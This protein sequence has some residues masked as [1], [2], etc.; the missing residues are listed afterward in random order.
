[1]PRKGGNKKADAPEV[2][3]LPVAAGDVG[4]GACVCRVARARARCSH[5][6]VFRW[7]ATLSPCLASSDEAAAGAPAFRCAVPMFV[8]TRAP[9]T[10]PSTQ[11]RFGDLQM[12]GS[13]GVDLST[14]PAIVIK[15][16][17]AVEGIQVRS[18]RHQHGKSCVCAALTPS[19]R[20]HS[21][22]EFDKLHSQHL[23]ELVELEKKYMNLYNP[24]FAKRKD[25]I[26][27]VVD[28]A[29]EDS[30]AAPA[31]V[32]AAAETAAAP[33]PTAGAAPP[34]PPGAAAAAPAAT[35]AKATAAAVPVGIPGFW[36]QAM[37]QHP[38]RA[39]CR[40]WFLLAACIRCSA[41]GH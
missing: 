27:G 29:A 30:D 20:A 19:P 8:L 18:R 25:I 6:C 38:V 26:T 32:D 5:R 39:P 3:E 34:P 16:L 33:Q 22:S 14:L 10:V 2:V 9:V 13:G 36:L 11:E 40:P 7:R 23:A 24:L 28:P 17:N 21:Q 1:M 41:G 4:D 12:G 37:K 15:R 31:L 35:D